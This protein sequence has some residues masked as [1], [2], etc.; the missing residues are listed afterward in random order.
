MHGLLKGGQSRDSS[1]GGYHAIKDAQGRE[2][3]RK[4]LK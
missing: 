4:R 3:S 1:G 2:E